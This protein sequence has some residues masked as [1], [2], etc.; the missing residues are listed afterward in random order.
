M[1]L[2]KNRKN[3]KKVV[4][5]PKAALER[6]VGGISWINFTQGTCASLVEFDGN[7]LITCLDENCQRRAQ[8]RLTSHL[9]TGLADHM[10]NNQQNGVYVIR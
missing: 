2:N 1:N 9:L 3:T 6:L 10:A 7:A 4:V 8:T 5:T